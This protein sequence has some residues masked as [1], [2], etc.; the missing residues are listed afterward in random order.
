[1]GCKGFR[2]FRGLIWAMFTERKEAGRWETGD[3]G[4]PTHARGTQRAE[5]A[6]V[7]WKA[8]PLLAV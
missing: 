3:W 8:L 4:D 5:C 2:R 6:I 7:A 1:M